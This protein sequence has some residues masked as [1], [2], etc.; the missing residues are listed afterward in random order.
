MNH[1]QHGDPQPTFHLHAVNEKVANNI[2]SFK[3]IFVIDVF[4]IAFTFLNLEKLDIDW[5]VKSIISKCVMKNNNVF[6]NLE[7]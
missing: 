3:D 7:A 4:E 1:H 2:N 6:S 5:F